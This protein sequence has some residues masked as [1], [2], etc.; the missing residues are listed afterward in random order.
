MVGVTHG[1]MPGMLTLLSQQLALLT[2]EDQIE[3]VIGVGCTANLWMGYPPGP[4]HVA[5]DFSVDWDM[6]HQA[7][8]HLEIQAAQFVCPA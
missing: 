1:V 6:P 3:A 5:D 7:V 4:G 8:G 2:I